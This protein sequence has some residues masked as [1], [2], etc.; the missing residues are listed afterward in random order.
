V[1]KLFQLSLIT[2][3]LSITSIIGYSQPKPLRIVSL[4]PSLTDLVIELDGANLL[5]GVL[6]FQQARPAVIANIP[7]VGQFG[8]FSL[9]KLIS[10]K[11]DLILLW[12]TSIKS[13]EQQQLNHLGYK[14]IMISPHTLDELATQIAFVGKQIGREQQGQTLVIKMHKE[15]AE[16]REKFYRERPLSVFYQLWGNPIYTIGKGQIIG[17]ALKIC[18]AR[19]VFDDL[20][21]PAPIVNTE[22]VL[23]RNPDIIIASQQSLLDAWQNWPMLKAV[24][25]HKLILFDNQNIART[26]Y[27]MLEATKQLCELLANY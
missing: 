2:F 21:S 27:A 11:P 26:D 6:D 18:G 8:Q 5:V 20:N 24:A 13:V 1:F 3:I 25:Q 12:P 22:R 4:S 10:L 7:S 14:I 17:D 16:L 15:L 23:A 19:N 9:E